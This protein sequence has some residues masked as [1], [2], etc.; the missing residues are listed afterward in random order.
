M[1]IFLHIFLYMFLLYLDS[2]LVNHYY[3]F[4]AMTN[5]QDIK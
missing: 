5:M 3:F 1:I 4:L 2:F